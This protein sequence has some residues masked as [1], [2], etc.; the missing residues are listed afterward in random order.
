LGTNPLSI[1]AP[2]A[3]D[4]PLTLDIATSRIA[5][6]KVVAALN[7]KQP[8]PEG[9]AVDSDGYPTTDPQRAL[10]G[11]LLPFGE[12]KGS[13]LAVLL[14]AMSVILGGGSFARDAV[15][16]WSDPSSRMNTGHLMIVID[17]DAFGGVSAA[18]DKVALLQ[19]RVRDSNPSAGPVNA[20]GDVEAGNAVR[21]RD[22]VPIDE[23]TV[24]ALVE[25][26]LTLGIS[27]PVEE[28]RG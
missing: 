27:M 19:K 5:Y 24:H 21:N 7:E 9:M 4:E 13:G 20:P 23:S 18:Q 1:S 11:A 6:G 17:A 2:S 22:S 3:S 26:S 12:H 10:D 8:I 28:R 16:I 25:M 14:E 15:D